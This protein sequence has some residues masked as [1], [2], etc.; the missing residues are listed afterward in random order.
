MS[1]FSPNLVGLEGRK[2]LVSVY[3][4]CLQER[5][6]CVLQTKAEYCFKSSFFEFALK[7][8]MLGHCFKVR[9]SELGPYIS[10]I[11]GQKS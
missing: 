4:D 7:E 8:L 6:F 3:R 11:D 9:G 10:W 1:T 2:R 5:Q